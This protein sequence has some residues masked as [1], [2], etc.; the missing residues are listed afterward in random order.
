MSADIDWTFVYI[1]IDLKKSVRICG[2][3]FSIFFKNSPVKL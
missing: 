3:N 2:S 1:G